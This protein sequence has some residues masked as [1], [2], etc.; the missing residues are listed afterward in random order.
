M[1]SFETIRDTFI[2]RNPSTFYGPDNLALFVSQSGATGSVIIDGITVPYDIGGKSIKNEV[3][4][5]HT[6]YVEYSTITGDPE[7]KYPYPYLTGSEEMSEASYVSGV[8]SG[9]VRI[10]EIPLSDVQARDGYYF[11]ETKTK[12]VLPFLLSSFD[13]PSPTF[14]RVSFSGPENFYKS[15]YNATRTDSENRR[16]TKRIVVDRLR[17]SPITGDYVNTFL[18]QNY[19]VILTYIADPPITLNKSFQNIPN[20][21]FAET[22]DSNYSSLAWSNIRYNGVEETR[23]NV[24]GNEPAL[25]FREFDGAIYP[26][27]SDV[28]TIKAISD[29]DREIETVYF[30]N[31]AN[32]TDLGGKNPSGSGATL[33]GALPVDSQI[34]KTGEEVFTP[35][36]ST[37][38]SVLYRETGNKLERI[39]SA[40]I[41][42]VD[43][44]T[45]FVTNE[46]GKVLKE[47]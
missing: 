30:V 9:S 35:P 21:L 32:G 45:V 22:Q 16:S 24:V 8:Q 6:V 29:S 36:T 10:L 28:T 3:R 33:E 4:D 5:S 1:S 41:Y 25:T 40:N 47:V 17:V 26:T 15:D 43:R 20:D 18:P 39:P 38:F 23:R 2:K 46:N 27:G 37:L 12:P 14:L 42:G 7:G 34:N 44:G 13:E 31:F 11:F 19:P